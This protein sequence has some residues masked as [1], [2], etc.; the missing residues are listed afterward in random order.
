MHRVG[1]LK[2]C[3]LEKEEM[4]RLLLRVTAHCNVLKRDNYLI[5]P[6]YFWSIRQVLQE[7]YNCPIM[8]IQGSA[9]NVT[10]KYF[11]YKETPE[12]IA[13]DLEFPL[14]VV[15]ELANNLQTI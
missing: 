5:L 14:E 7:K 9:G 13:E 3:D 10:P 4:K 15:E 8:M 11:D 6:D 12:E 2:V 1:I